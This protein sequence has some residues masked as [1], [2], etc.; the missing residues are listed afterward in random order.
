MMTRA[1]VILNLFQDI[2]RCYCVSLKQVQV[3]EE[4]VC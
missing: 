2:K 4:V 1:F 3:D